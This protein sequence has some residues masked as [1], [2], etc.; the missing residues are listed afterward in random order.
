MLNFIKNTNN[1]N[2]VLIYHSSFDKKNKA[3]D[4]YIHNVTPNNIIT[5]INF[6]KKYYKIIPV[7]DFFSPD[8]G[9]NNMAITFD[10]GYKNLFT[11]IVPELIK[12]KIYS[13]IF[14][15]GSSFDKKPFWREKITYLMSNKPLFSEFKHLYSSKFEYQIDFDSF[16]RDSKSFKFNS[17][18]LDHSINEF[19]AQKHISLESNLLDDKSKLIDS[20]YV[21]YGNHTFNH[22]VLSTLSYQ[23]QLKEI[24]TNHNFLHSLNLNLSQVF[25]F[26]F[27]GLPDFNENSLSALSDLGITKV[28]LNN[29]LINRQSMQKLKNSNVN[30]LERFT[31]SNNK[32]LFYYRMLKNMISM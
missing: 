31:T 18:D 2:I 26:P 16:Y 4:E 28:L 23:Q 14:L 32:Y 6:L 9:Q 21:N 7:D 8:I 1:G 15:I 17:M 24:E 5:Q 19:L 12:M 25:A 29:N 11:T 20:E 10:D 30:Y 27:G 22:Y 3:R 13:T